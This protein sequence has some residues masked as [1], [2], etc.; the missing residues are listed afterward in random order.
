MT[1]TDSRDA[2][3]APEIP[4][5]DCLSSL[6][7]AG[8]DNFE[9]TIPYHDEC[10]YLL[11]L[12]EIKGHWSAC[13]LNTMCDYETMAKGEGASASEALWNT[14][15]AVFGTQPWTGNTAAIPARLIAL[16]AVLWAQAT[17]EVADEDAEAASNHARAVADRDAAVAKAAAASEAVAP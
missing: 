9:I 8:W 10:P 6:L 2:A 14:A 4:A 16:A 13:V 15:S 11:T 5:S 7:A 1:V 12:W 17:A 3:L